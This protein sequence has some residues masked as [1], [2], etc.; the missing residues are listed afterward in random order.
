MSTTLFAFQNAHMRTALA[1][2]PNPAPPDW[3]D[4]LR[5]GRLQGGPL[6]I[7]RHQYLR[8]ARVLDVVWA[9]LLPLISPRLQALLEE[10]AVS[11]WATYPVVV[12]QDL[13][14]LQGY[15]ALGITG[16]CRRVA[17]IEDERH[18][19]ERADGFAVVKGLEIDTS[20]WDGADL[21]MGSDSGFVIATGRVRALFKRAKIG[22]VS[23]VPAEDVTFTVDPIAR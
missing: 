20:T 1:A 10:S 12:E 23:F 16:R 3:H 18:V 2:A 6:H 5:T 11:G 17:F 7:A 8:G 15:R 22:N 19:V 9:E 4:Y 14:A 21:F 13:S